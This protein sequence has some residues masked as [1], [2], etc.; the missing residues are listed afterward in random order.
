MLAIK[1]TRVT[2][3]SQTITIRKNVSVTI[4]VFLLPDLGELDLCSQVSCAMGL[5]H[6]ARLETIVARYNR[7][8]NKDFFGCTERHFNFLKK[9]TNIS[10]YLEEKRSMLYG[11]RAGD[12][13]VVG[14]LTGFLL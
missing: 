5:R 12:G 2:S 6:D 9:F 14:L 10:D 4:N 7:T 8:W 3:S 1:N 13:V 11:Q